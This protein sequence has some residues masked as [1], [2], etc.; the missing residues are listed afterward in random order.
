MKRKIKLSL[1]LLSIILLISTVGMAK[2]LD[3]TILYT[4]DIHAQVEP[5]K[6]RWLEEEPLMGGFANIASYVKEVKETEKNTVFLSAGDYFTGPSISSL[7]KGEAIID[8]MNYMDYDLA[9]IGNHEFDHGWRNFRDLMYKA[10][11]PILGANIFYKNTNINFAKPY[12][13]LHKDG[14]KIGVIGILGRKAA[15]ETIL[16]TFVD[17]LEFRE[18][19]P[20]VQHYVNE[21]EPLVDLIVVLAHEGKA[22]LQSATAEGDPQRVLNKDIE[23]A[24]E[25]NGIDVLITGHAHRGIEKPIKVKGTDT[26]LV[27][28]YGLGTRVGYLNLEIEKESEKI[29]SYKGYLKRIFADDINADKAVGNRVKY[30]N[31]EIDSIVSEVIGKSKVDLIRNYKEESNIGNLINDALKNEYNA[32]AFTNSGGIR[33]DIDAGEIT[34]GDVLKAFPFSNNAVTLELQGKT[35]LEVLE[36]SL[37]ME[38]GVLQQSGIKV[39]YDPDKKIGNR[40]IK[41]AVNG[42]EIDKDKWYKVVTNDFVST[43]GDSYTMFSK[44][45]NII[46]TGKLISKTLV[47]YIREKEV[48]ES[49][50]EDRIVP[51]NK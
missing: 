7:T 16:K 27:S 23:L 5:M 48:I 19:G 34:V 38:Y 30:W 39:K 31:N 15:N 6:A 2:T 32:I 33:A 26:L 50:I 37:S 8:L 13:I 14:L 20:I 11:F 17:E 40:I 24:K 36:Q 49:E 10:D 22:G 25:V 35:L 47:E 29:V 41:A 21:L 3:T 46:N 18:Q 4:N 9:V 42:E 44:G 43:G 12:E 28:T 1:F 51:V 45:R